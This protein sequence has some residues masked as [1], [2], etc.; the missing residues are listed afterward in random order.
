MSSDDYSYVS[1]MSKT[2]PAAID[3]IRAE[4]GN[5]V[6]MSKPVCTEAAA[7][8]SHRKEAALLELDPVSHPVDHRQRWHTVH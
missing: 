7:A 4:W 5:A 1:N 2:I 8:V 3:S 6:T